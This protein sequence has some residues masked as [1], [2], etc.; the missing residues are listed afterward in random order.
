M[1]FQQ[2][3]QL[4]HT[5]AALRMTGSPTEATKA[6]AAS[7]SAMASGVPGTVGTPHSS[8]NL[9]ASSL[10]PIACSCQ[11]S[12][13]DFYWLMDLVRTSLRAFSLSPT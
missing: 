8:A 10:S 11:D 5:M 12:G 9:R 2:Q 1:H 3:W 6:L 4:A 13:F 7:R